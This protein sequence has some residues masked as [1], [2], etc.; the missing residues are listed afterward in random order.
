MGPS[1]ASSP[2]QTPERSVHK[3]LWG[4]GTL[5]AIPSLP[6]QLLLEVALPRSAAYSVHKNV[7]TLFTTN[8]TNPTE[9]TS[10]LEGT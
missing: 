1:E 10:Y 8:T 3:D 6:C 2:S 7:H 5:F 9:S 4:V